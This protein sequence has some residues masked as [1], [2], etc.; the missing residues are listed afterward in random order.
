LQFEEFVTMMSRPGD[1]PM[2]RNANEIWE[3]MVSRE[4]N[5]QR[6]RSSA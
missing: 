2:E 5:E 4:Q 1:E 6:R 3:L